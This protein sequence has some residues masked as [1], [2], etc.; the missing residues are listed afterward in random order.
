MSEPPRIWNTGELVQLTNEHA[1]AIDAVVLLGSPNGRS[2]AVGFDVFFAGYLNGTAL[3]WDEQA[4][5]YRGLHCG[6]PF[7]VTERASADNDP[8]TLTRAKMQA[9]V[10]AGLCTEGEAD[11]AVAF[12]DGLANLEL[13]GAIGEEEAVARLAEFSL[14]QLAKRGVGA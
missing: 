6:K 12:M 4:S 9:M 2:L 5:V 11:E 14:L 10:A 1:D 7:T 13:T 8:A 3:L